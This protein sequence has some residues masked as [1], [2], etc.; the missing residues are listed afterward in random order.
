MS[1]STG[2]SKRLAEFLQE[3]FPRSYHPENLT[4]LQGDASNRHYFRYREKD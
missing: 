2:I 4:R 3:E 1:D